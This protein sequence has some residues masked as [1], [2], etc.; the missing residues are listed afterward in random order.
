MHTF[1]VHSNESACIKSGRLGLEQVIMGWFEITQ[2]DNRRELT[3]AQLLETMCL[4]MYP[5]PTEITYYQG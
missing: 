2:Y 4:T 1:E 3:I 5:W